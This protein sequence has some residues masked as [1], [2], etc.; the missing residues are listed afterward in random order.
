M[1]HRFGSSDPFTVGAE[2]ELFLVDP[3]SYELTHSSEQVLAAMD[4][5]QPAAGHEAYAS[6][7]ELRSPPQRSAAEAVA[8]L[9]RAAS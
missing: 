2:E 8:T 1:E 6:E 4:A 5:E 7:L 9:A 3:D